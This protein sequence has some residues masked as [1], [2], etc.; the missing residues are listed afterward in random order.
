[1]NKKLITALLLIVILTAFTGCSPAEAPAPEET[2]A[3]ET[4]TEEPATGEP[5]SMYTDGTYKVIYSHTDS[6]DWIPKLDLVIKDGMI[7]SAQMDYFKPTGEL[8]SEDEGYAA[9]MSGVSGI[10]PADAYVEMNARL[11]AA[12]DMDAVDVVTGATHSFEGF[13]EMVDV[14]LEAAMAGNTALIV[15]PMNT[16]YSASEE[17]YDERGWKGE[18]AIT[19]ENDVITSV[20]YNEANEE[21]LTKRDDEAYNA[22]FLE[23]KGVTNKDSVIALEAQL[24]DV[25]DINSVDVVTGATSS[26]TKFMELAKQA[27][28]GRKAYQ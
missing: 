2:T 24:L 17:A 26:S 12:Q 8:K 18:I 27:L 4:T 9:T 6:H 14:A 28:A 25:Q 5:S 22:A 21:G 19:F 16:T 3:V 13:V 7:D 20:V 11:V 23:A 1:M 10:T 15:L